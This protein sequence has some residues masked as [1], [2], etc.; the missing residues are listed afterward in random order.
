[1]MRIRVGRLR[2]I[3]REELTC[4]YKGLGQ[5][6]PIRNVSGPF[7]SF[8]ADDESL[9]DNDSL[10]IEPKSKAKIRSWMHGPC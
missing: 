7:S 9:D 2:Q 6:Q 1:M 5:R 10:W 4:S 3:I 8:L